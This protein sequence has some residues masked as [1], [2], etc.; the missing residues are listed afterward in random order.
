MLLPTADK[1]ESVYD[2]L[3]LLLRLNIINNSDV[4]GIPPYGKTYYYDRHRE[5]LL[6][7]LRKLKV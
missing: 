1:L 5:R 6:H 4:L 7:L 3:M 2:I